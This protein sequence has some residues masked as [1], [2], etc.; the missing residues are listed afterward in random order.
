MKSLVLPITLLVAAT[1]SPINSGYNAPS[2]GSSFGGS[3]FGGS[4]F[5]DSSFSGGSFSH[6]GGGSFSHGGGGSFSH[7]GGDIGFGDGCGSGQVR[8]ANGECVT[9]QV[10]RNLYLYA[11]PAQRIETLPPAN[12]PNPKVHLNYV[13]VR[14]EN[15]IGGARPVVVPP[16][17]QK[18]LVYVLNRRP[19]A[20]NT[21]V[22]EVPSTPTQPEVFFV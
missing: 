20:Q 14:T 9:P 18:T 8:T 2:G 21:E 5:S 10:T 16:P 6:G 13:F 15:A 11:A 12:L 1:A 3:S 4:S 7:G 19:N 17:K 22:I